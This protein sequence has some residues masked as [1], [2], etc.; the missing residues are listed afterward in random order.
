MSPWLRWAGVAVSRLLL[1]PVALVVVPFL[2]DEDRKNHP[3]WGADDATDLSWKNIAWTNGVHNFHNRDVVPY[4]TKGSR[5]NEMEWHGVRTR[6]RVSDDGDYVSYR[7]T[8]GKPRNK[9]KREF[10][11]GWTMADTNPKMRP[12]LQLR[13]F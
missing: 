1:K 3:V 10:Y 6:R 7:R 12:T 4:T 8:W 13:I 2:N 9:G 11:A 5:D